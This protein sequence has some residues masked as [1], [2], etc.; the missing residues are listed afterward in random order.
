MRTFQN[1]FEFVLAGAKGVSKESVLALYLEQVA[2]SGKLKPDVAQYRGLKEG[3]EDKTY[4]FLK[5]SLMRQLV[6][7]KEAANRAAQERALGNTQK[8]LPAGGKGDGGKGGKGD[9]GK[10]IGGHV[11]S[12]QP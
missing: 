11:Q 3:R 2:K 12:L 10:G 6:I 9:G 4:E 1:N 8:G 5:A 7:E